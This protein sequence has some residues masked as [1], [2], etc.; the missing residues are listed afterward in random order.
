MKNSF[1][2]LGF[3]I[4]LLI[5]CPPPTPEPGPD[6]GGN[7][8]GNET[9]KE[10]TV[11]FD[12]NG[13]TGTIAPMKVK[14]GTVITLPEASGL[15]R[16]YFTFSDWKISIFGDASYRPGDKYVINADTVFFADRVTN[17]LS[18]PIPSFSRN[19]VIPGF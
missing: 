9:A 11:S 12:P 4:S 17:T 19:G 1:L 6:E 16:Q 13:G 8:S 5:S 14:A 15:S 3:L 18:T 7:G 2:I 10:F